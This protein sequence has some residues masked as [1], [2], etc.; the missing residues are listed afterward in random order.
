MDLVIVEDSHLIRGQLLRL[1]AVP[2]IDLVGIA[3]DAAQ[4][5]RLILETKPHAVILDLALSEG[6]GLQVLRD[7]RAAG[8]D[9]RVLVL[10]N[11][12]GEALRHACEALGISGFYDK[13]HEAAQCI[14]H[15]MSWLPSAAISGGEGRS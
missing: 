12:A 11:H 7:V 10:T 4:A 8:C 6:S 1:V 3:A 2:E 9:T 14:A 5:V 15:L 13:S